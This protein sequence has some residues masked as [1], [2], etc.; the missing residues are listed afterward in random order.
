MRFDP[1]LVEGVLVRRYK[2]FI[3]DVVLRDGSEITA[4]VANTGPMTGCAEPGFEVALSHHPDKGRKLPW[5]WE[6]VR[7]APPWGDGGSWALVNTIRANAV[8]GEALRARKIP[9]F[10]GYATVRPEVRWRP[11]KKSRLDFLLEDHEEGAPP[12]FV[13]VKNVTLREEGQALFPDTVTTRGAR[14]VRDMTTLVREGRAKAAM[15]FLV[16]RSDCSGFRPAAH[17]DPDYAE[18]V[19]EALGAGVGI[20]AWQMEVNPQGMELTSELETTPPATGD[21][22][23]R[24]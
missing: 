20:H 14:H 11:D 9:A 15:F 10:A 16:A 12:C 1:P 24:R 4:H 21:G 23:G 6:I 2:R 3:A 7:P 17:L 19:T 22:P 13:E 18:A 8:V 5:S